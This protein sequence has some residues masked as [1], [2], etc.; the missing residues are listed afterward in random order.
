MYVSAS[1]AF[2]NLTSEVNLEAKIECST[3]VLDSYLL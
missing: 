2:K 3:I 1:C